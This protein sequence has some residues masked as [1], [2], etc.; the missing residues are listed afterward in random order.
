MVASI[1]A[2]I[3][4]ATQVSLQQSNHTRLL[5][6]ID[7][8]RLESDDEIEQVTRFCQR[9]FTVLGAVAAVCVY[10][11][12]IST[13]KSVL[14]DS[15]VKVATVVNFPT[16]AGSIAATEAEIGQ[17]LAMGADEI[18]VVIPY[19]LLLQGEHEAVVNYLQVC[20]AAAT[21]KCL[22]VILETAALQSRELIAE[23]SILAIKHGADFIKTSTGK[24]VAGASMEAVAV[25]LQTIKAH[26]DLRP[27]GIKV[28]GGVKT[29]L[30]AQQYLT[31]CGLIMGVDWVTSARVRFGASQL[32]ASLLQAA[33]FAEVSP[34]D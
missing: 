10:P 29:V 33:G 28:S 16:G 27:V 18:D 13:A 3:S 14:V 24:Y 11:A 4:K 20:R 32:L 7:L 34:A 6:L 30:Q 15:N 5:R 17:A 1:E 26:A 23:A 25:I 31:L 22:K 8:T 19:A 9:A 21:D 12:F 2:L